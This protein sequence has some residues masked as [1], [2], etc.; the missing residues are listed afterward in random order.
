MKETQTSGTWMH[1]NVLNK[2]VIS[3]TLLMSLK[4][5]S[6]SLTIRISLL[7]TENCLPYPLLPPTAMA[8]VSRVSLT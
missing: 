8:T 2:N 1:V 4:K 3:L 6:E 5:L 7:A